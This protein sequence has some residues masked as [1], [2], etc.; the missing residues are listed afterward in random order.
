MT[1]T[2]LPKY[3]ILLLLILAINKSFAQQYSSSSLYM[4]DM[5]L[6]NPAF[7]GTGKKQIFTADYHT[8]LT[9]F[10]GHPYRLFITYE[11]NLSKINSGIGT[12]V[13]YNEIGPFTEFSG[14]LLYDYQYK[15]GEQKKV[16]FGTSLTY[17]RSS[18]DENEIRPLDP[19]DPVLA[20]SDFSSNDVSLHLAVLLMV[21][22]TRVG[23]GAYNLLKTE[24]NE[25]LAQA[26]SRVLFFNLENKYNLV[27]WLS[28][29]PSLLYQTDF[30]N[31]WLDVNTIIEVKK[32]VLIGAN[33]QIRG[34]RDNNLNING[35]VAI[36]DRAE[37]LLHAYSSAYKKTF[38]GLDPSLNFEAMVRF[39][40]Q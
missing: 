39:K 21:K 38:K 37:I 1:R 14:N 17:K 3:I 11:N 2:V 32:L 10:N 5:K 29:R 13:S 18:I 27:E 34:D 4:Y 6:V 40:I 36:K 19:N 15:L 33:Y 35:G 22:S 23:L 7:A 8:T 30:S 9:N 31:T 24:N 26:D 20:Q 16:S 12:I 28:L 25:Y